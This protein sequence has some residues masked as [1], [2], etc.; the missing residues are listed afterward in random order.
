MVTLLIIPAVL[1]AAALAVLVLA[2][3]QRQL[4]YWLAAYIRGLFRKAPAA[5]G[6]VHVMVCIADHFE[7]AWNNVDLERERARMD[8]WMRRLPSIATRHRDADGMP[9]RYTF[10]FPIEQ[11][12]AEHLDKLADLCGRGF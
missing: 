1:V 6:P 7:P 8:V 10:F 11:Y 4:Q 9:L 12:R 3:R 2:T 5:P